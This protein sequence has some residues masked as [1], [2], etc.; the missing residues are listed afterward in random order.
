M[1]YLKTT[2]YRSYEIKLNGLQ[3]EN[4]FENRNA[5]F[6]FVAGDITKMHSEETRR[7]KR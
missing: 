4:F 2:L 7:E 5:W 6:G 3:E 1:F